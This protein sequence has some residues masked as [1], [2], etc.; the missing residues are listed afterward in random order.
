VQITLC[1]YSGPT[2]LSDVLLLDNGPVPLHSTAA[3]GEE[4]EGKGGNGEEED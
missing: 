1:Q 2:P 3:F 4:I